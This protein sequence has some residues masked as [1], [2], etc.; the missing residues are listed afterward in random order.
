V[1]GTLRVGTQSFDLQ[2]GP[3]LAASLSY[4]AVDDRKARPFVLFS[5]SL[6]VSSASTE[7]DGSSIVATDAR[8]GVSA[9]KTIAGKMTPYVTAR[10]FGGPVF[11]SYGGTDASGTDVHHYQVGAGFS[12]SLGKVDVHMEVAPLGERSLA[13][14]AGL[15]F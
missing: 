15:A 12:L 5:L 10:A 2:P 13:A 7:P 4:R 3:L 8:L 9:G 11:W 1:G 6:A 14:G